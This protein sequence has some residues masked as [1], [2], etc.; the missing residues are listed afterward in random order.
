M[1]EQVAQPAVDPRPPRRV[2]ALQRYN[3]KQ[4][5]A[6][7]AKRAV[8][9]TLADVY[10]QTPAT[11]GKARSLRRYLDELLDAT[12]VTPLAIAR[13]LSKQLK[14]KKYVTAEGTQKRVLDHPTIQKAIR[15]ACRLR[16]WFEA[17][18]VKANYGCVIVHLTPEKRKLIEDMRG[19]PLVLATDPPIDVESEEVEE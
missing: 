5:A 9:G 6:R 4:R 7:R 10:G 14:A 13:A 18:P 17:E 2:A 8:T 12:G 1:D 19:S 15:D 3:E 11:S 16:G